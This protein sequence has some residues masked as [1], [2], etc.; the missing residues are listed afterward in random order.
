VL[1]VNANIFDRSQWPQYPQ[2]KFPAENPYSADKAV[3]GKLL[4]WDEQLSADDSTACGTC[5]RAAAGGSDPRPSLP[6]YLG[7]PGKD[8]VRGT[9]DDPKGSPGIAAC[10]QAPDAAP[11]P[12]MDA[13]FGT[14]PQV[15]RR[16]AMT[17]LDAM[18]SEKMFW[19]GRV[20]ATLRDPI[21]DQVVIANGAAL[22]AQALAPVTNPVEMACTGRSWEMAAR[23]IAAARPLALA[24]SLPP[25]LLAA[26]QSAA[27]YS[28]LFQKVF[29]DNNVTPV[30]IVMAIAT[31][32]RTLTA[33]QTPWD[34]WR[35]GDDAALSEQEM[36]GFQ[37]FTLKGACSCCHTVPLFALPQLVDDAFHEHSWD[38]GGAEMGL[39]KP[40]DYTNPTFRT[41]TVR[42]AGLREAAGLLHDGLAPG[43]KLEDL[44]AAYN[45]APVRNVHFCRRALN[46]SDQEQVDLV[47]FIRNALTDPRVASEAPPFDR[48]KLA[49]ELK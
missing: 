39:D 8:G 17:V 42:N 15:G 1:D 21:T 13:I 32:E 31:Y 41:A 38:G 44:I 5:H 27:T 46:L 36:R 3:L 9:A 26:Q 33:N 12:R 6:G 24:M 48:P 34:R 4:F 28:E 7:N 47:R 49:S 40:G 23:K 20:G 37:V 25:D 35:A 18:F 2:V 11:T 10:T 29:G 30:R 45:K 43:N 16:R 22:E 19:D 14:N